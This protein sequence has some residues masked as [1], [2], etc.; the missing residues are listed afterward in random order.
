MKE[1]G[2]FSGKIIDTQGLPKREVQYGPLGVPKEKDQLDKLISS[3][4]GK[5]PFEAN[6][7][8]QILPEKIQFLGS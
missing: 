2:T 1:I 3:T 6:G 4:I 7:L 5:V 8:A